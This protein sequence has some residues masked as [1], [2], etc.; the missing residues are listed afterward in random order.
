MLSALIAIA[1][2]HWAVLVLPGFN[3]VLISRLAAGGS[4]RQALSAVAGM[5]TATLV[6]ALLA[7]AGVGLV[8]TAHPLLRHAAQVAGGLYLVHLAFKLWRS[9]RPASA[10]PASIF[11]TAAA[12]R[13]GF[14]TSALNPKIAL[15]YGSVFATSLPRDPSSTLVMLAVLLVFA[16]SVVWHSSLALLLSRSRVQKAYLRRYQSFN[17]VSGA[18]VG[19]YG[20]KLIATVVGDFRS[21][22][23]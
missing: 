11:G 21:K 2:L 20:V 23:G 19:A 17:Q 6:W 4:R 22:V 9:N 1:V 3:F 13:T 8:F 15:F 10:D 18:L 14:L 16:N 7:V 5:T 12:F